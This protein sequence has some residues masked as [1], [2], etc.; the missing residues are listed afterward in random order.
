MILEGGTVVNCTVCGAQYQE[1]AAFCVGC[2]SNLKD[3][4]PPAEQ[5]PEQERQ[6]YQAQGGTAPAQVPVPLE[7]RQEARGQ[8][9]VIQDN[10]PM[11]LGDYMITM[12]VSW[13]PLVGLVLLL[14]WSFS[15][16]INENKKNY[17]RARLIYSLIAL[18]LAVVL[19]VGLVPL[20]YLGNRQL[21]VPFGDYFYYY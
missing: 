13:I 1:G 8:S 5:P 3:Q 4:K 2:G 18:G 12:L 20:F 17:A 10:R 7:Q 11:S 21:N 9:G 15:T 6:Y 16:G 19:L 14:V